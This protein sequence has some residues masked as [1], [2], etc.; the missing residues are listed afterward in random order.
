MALKHYS[1]EDG[2]NKENTVYVTEY[3]ETWFVNA[4]ASVSRTTR[5]QYRH[6]TEAGAVAEAGRVAAK[7]RLRLRDRSLAI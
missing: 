3:D 1:P 7:F 5:Y 6:I 4:P 2:D